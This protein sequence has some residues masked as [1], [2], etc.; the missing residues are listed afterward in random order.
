MSKITV[1][2][3]GST[4]EKN[5]KQFF[6]M[7][8]TCW[9]AF[10]NMSLPE[11][12]RYLRQR[13]D[14][15]FNTIL[16]NILPQWDRGLAKGEQFCPFVKEG[17]AELRFSDIPMDYLKNAC[18]YLELMQHYDMTPVLVLLWSNYTNGT[19]FDNLWGHIPMCKEDVPDYVHAVAELYRPYEPMY[20][21]CGD[22][23]FSDRVVDDY[24]LP[25]LIAL[26]ETA[27]EALASLHSCGDGFLSTEEIE[28]SIPERLLYSDLLDFYCY[29]SGHLQPWLERCTKCAIAFRGL[30]IRKPVL[31]AEP[32]YEGWDWGSVVH[33]REH[34]R[35]STWLSVLSGADAGLSYGAQGVWLWYRDGDSFA[36]YDRKGDPLLYTCERPFTGW[37]AMAFEGVQD[38]VF[39]RSIIE[40]YG[41]YDVTPDTRVEAVTELTRL[42]LCKGDAELLLYM[43]RNQLTRVNIPAEEYS[44]ELFDLKHQKRIPAPIT[45][46]SEGFTIS[47]PGV[48]SDML[49]VGRRFENTGKAD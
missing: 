5:G 18:R 36:P 47:Y 27:P 14:Q 30:K 43:P 31:N 15:G 22:T 44:F 20:F 9:S 41:I 17:A 4:F 6:M 42:A 23:D 25:A 1:A 12:E 3:N 7:A 10:T 48:N 24:Y 11:F 33:D 45:Q 29:Q 26:K 38:R 21:V 2:R 16:L 32:C 35:Q 39:A 13:K 34:V 37:Q 19:F 40:Q 49:L 28:R 46:D 8:D